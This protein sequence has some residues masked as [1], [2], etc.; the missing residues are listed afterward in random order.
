MEPA[1]TKKTQE[2]NSDS[3]ESE[4]DFLPD[5]HVYPA[6]MVNGREF[7]AHLMSKYCWCHPV[8]KDFN[9]ITGVSLWSHD[10]L[11]SS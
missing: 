9:P 6:F 1:S 3:T 11:K 2:S 7:T 5:I 8:K 4:C 10:D